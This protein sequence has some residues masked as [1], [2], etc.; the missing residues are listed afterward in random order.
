MGQVNLILKNPKDALKSFN[1]VIKKNPEYEMVFNAKLM[2]TQAYV[3]DR[4]TFLELSASLEK[5]IK[6]RK[7]MEYKDQVYFALA[8]LQLKKRKPKITPI[9]V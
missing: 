8:G 1:E 9:I 3:E 6:D 2:R 5:M 4:S 7:N